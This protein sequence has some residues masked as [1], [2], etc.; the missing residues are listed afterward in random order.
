MNETALFYTFST[1]AQ[2]LAA[3]FAMLGAFVL[4]RVSGGQPVFERIREYF[5]L[6]QSR[7][8]PIKAEQA[9]RRAGAA[10]V[11]EIITYADL[12]AADSR[13]SEFDEAH[14]WHGMRATILSRFRW[15]LRL[16]LVV[17]TASI[18]AIPLSP[19][20]ANANWLAWTSAVLAVIGAAACLILYFKLIGALIPSGDW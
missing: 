8:D 17:V 16:T 20:L 4:F 15:S 18:A 13:W 1:V 19:A 11:R 9:V 14:R 10:G 7:F 5:R 12:D 6:N 3:A 2:T